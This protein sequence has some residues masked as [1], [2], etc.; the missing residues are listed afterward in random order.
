[1]TDI[2]VETTDQRLTYVRVQLRLEQWEVSVL[3][4]ENPFL[5]HGFFQQR[6]QSFSHI[7][8]VLANFVL[9]AALGVASVISSE[10][11]ASATTRQRM[12]QIFTL[13]QLTQAQVENASPV[14]IH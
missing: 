11:I 6:F 4:G 5:E 1:M 14:T 9:H 8:E 3:A 2:R 7:L 12:E 13:G 10:T